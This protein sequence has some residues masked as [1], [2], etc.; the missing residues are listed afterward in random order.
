MTASTL[1]APLAAALTIAYE[2]PIPDWFP[3]V[4]PTVRDIG[5]ADAARVPLPEGNRPWRVL[6]HLRIGLELWREALVGGAF[7]PA[8]HGAGDDWMPVADPSDDAWRDLRER[9]LA[10][11]RAFAASVAALSDEDLLEP[12][13]VFDMTRLEVVLSTLAHTAYHAGELAPLRLAL[14]R[15]R[16]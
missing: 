9:T 14:A 5:A 2:D 4:E 12:D 6:D 1:A 11:S 15:G 10:A 16:D 3:P 13:G 7:D 8:A